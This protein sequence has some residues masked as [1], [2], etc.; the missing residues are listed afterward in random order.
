MTNGLALFAHWSVCQKLNCVS[1]VQFSYVALYAFLRMP[2]G[3]DV[4]VRVCLFSACE[5]DL[6]RR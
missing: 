2:F 4:R 5:V 6:Y 3:S 1:L